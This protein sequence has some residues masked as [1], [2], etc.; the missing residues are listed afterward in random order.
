VEL[1]YLLSGTCPHP[2]TQRDHAGGDRGG[3]T[4]G[5]AVRLR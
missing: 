4:R 3:V 1:R 2:A 5:G